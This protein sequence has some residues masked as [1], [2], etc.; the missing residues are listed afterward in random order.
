VLYTNGTPLT[1]KRL[2]SVKNAL[3]PEGKIIVTEHTKA[4]SFID[5]LPEIDDGLLPNVFVRRSQDLNLVNRGGLLSDQTTSIEN[6]FCL[7]PKLHFT[8]NTEGKVVFC[9]DDFFNT[10]VIGDL[11]KQSLRDIVES[12]HYKDV[13]DSLQRGERYKFQECKD[14]NRIMGSDRSPTIPAIDF[15]K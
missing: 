6:Q 3:G 1:A 8:V 15:K 14:C 5:R 7:M 9:P 11:N 2:A 10:G 12:P 13:R 4:A